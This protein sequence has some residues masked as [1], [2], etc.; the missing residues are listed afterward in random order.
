MILPHTASASD[1]FAWST[2]EDRPKLW[3]NIRTAFEEELRP[4]DPEKVAPVVPYLY[5]RIDRVGCRGDSCI[6][7]VLNREREDDDPYYYFCEAFSYDVKSGVKMQ[8]AVGTTKALWRW[9][10]VTLASFEPDTIDIVFRYKSCLEC[11]SEDLL[12]SFAYRE[13]SASW[14][15]RI[16]PVNDPHILIGSDAQYGYGVI[17]YYD[18][19]HT[20]RDLNDDGFAD[21]AVRCRTIGNADEPGR[22]DTVEDETIIYTVKKGSPQRTTVK[23]GRELKRIRKILCEGHTGSPLCMVEGKRQQ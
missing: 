7:L 23:S 1:G 13:K 17:Y 8:L 22:K 18:C 5:R 9:S 19:L 11:E 16:W 21:L 10:L 2:E 12:S 6:V 20:V 14:D 4:D 15:T 3:K